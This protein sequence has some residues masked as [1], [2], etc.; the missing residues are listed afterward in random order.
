MIQAV[1]LCGT[2]ARRDEVELEPDH[3]GFLI[4]MT[5]AQQESIATSSDQGRRLCACMIEFLQEYAP[6]WIPQHSER[7][8]FVLMGL[9]QDSKVYDGMLKQI[10]HDS[11]DDSGFYALDVTPLEIAQEIKLVQKSLTQH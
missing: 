10:P 3:K 1:Y 2:F 5:R 11:V 6:E 4:L 9:D 8:V 7:Y